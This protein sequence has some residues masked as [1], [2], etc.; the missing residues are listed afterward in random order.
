MLIFLKNIIPHWV[1]LNCDELE[2]GWGMGNGQWAINW[3]IRIID[4][5]LYKNFPNLQLFIAIYLYFKLI[6]TFCFLIQLWNI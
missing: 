1:K 3:I 2:M 4:Q 5:Q 6:F